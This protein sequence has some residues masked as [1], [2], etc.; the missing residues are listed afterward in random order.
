MD[1]PAVSPPEEESNPRVD[2]EDKE[3]ASSP[4]FAN[5]VVLFQNVILHYYTATDALCRGFFPMVLEMVGFSSLSW[6][7]YAPWDPELYV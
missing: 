2:G 6:G 4:S 5:Y 7:S 3:G 1:S